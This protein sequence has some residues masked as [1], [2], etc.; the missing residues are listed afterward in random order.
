MRNVLHFEVD[1]VCGERMV[2]LRLHEAGDVDVVLREDARHFR[3][4]AG[5]VVERNAQ[6]A[7]RPAR[8]LAP[9][10]VEPVIVDPARQAAAI[11]SVYFDAFAGLR[12]PTMRSPG[13]G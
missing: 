1:L 10:Q 2:Q 6:P 5:P 11:D 12:N 13:T 8:T 4:R 9:R 3:Q 7:D